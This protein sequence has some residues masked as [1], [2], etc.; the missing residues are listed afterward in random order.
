MKCAACLAPSADMRRKHWC[1]S[2]V[3]RPGSAKPSFP[4]SNLGGTSSKAASTSQRM[5]KQLFLKTWRQTKATGLP[6]GRR[7]MFP[8]IVRACLH[9]QH[10]IMEQA[11]HV[12]WT[13]SRHAQATG[14]GRH[15]NW[16]WITTASNGRQ[17]IFPIPA[18][19]SPVCRWICPATAGFAPPRDGN[20]TGAERQSPATVRRQPLAQVFRQ[21]T[22]VRR[23]IVRRQPL[24][25]P[26]RQG[27]E[28]GR[29][30]NQ[31]GRIVA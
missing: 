10:G 13:A 17:T 15:G 30:S 4:S 23:R 27:R 7:R 14:S 5:P 29:Q 25:R 11:R 12:T 20:N 9:R 31:A 26:C 22:A 1:H 2:Q 18:P 6:Y 8:L 19:R 28:A 16:L 3:V 21:G 24:A